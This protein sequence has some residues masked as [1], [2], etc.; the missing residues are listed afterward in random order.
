[1]PR[2]PSPGTVRAAYKTKAGP[3]V[4][5]PETGKSS[6]EGPTIRQHHSEM[7]RDVGIYYHCPG[8]GSKVSDS[9]IIR[10]FP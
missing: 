1:M 6:R 4:R 3:Q 8:D 10:R 9:D 5:D 7:G 2:F